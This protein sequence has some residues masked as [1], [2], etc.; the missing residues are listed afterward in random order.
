MPV[1]RMPAPQRKSSEKRIKM[2][3]IISALCDMGYDVCDAKEAICIIETEKL[4]SQFDYPYGSFDEFK[5]H[6]LTGEFDMKSIDDMIMSK[7]RRE[8]LQ[9]DVANGRLHIAY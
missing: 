5:K 9:K 1:P 7:E 2:H 3:R 6:V 8:Q 4:E